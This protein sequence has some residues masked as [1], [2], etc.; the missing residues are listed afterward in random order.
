MILE[1]N[2]TLKNNNKWR[3]ANWDQHLYCSVNRIPA[4]TSAVTAGSSADYAHAVSSRCGKAAPP[5][6]AHCFCLTAKTRRPC[7]GPISDLR[8]R[9]HRLTAAAACSQCG[10]SATLTWDF[11]DRPDVELRPRQTGALRNSISRA[12]LTFRLQKGCATPHS[13]PRAQAHVHLQPHSDWHLCKT[14]LTAL[15][16]PS[17]PT[18]N[19]MSK[20]H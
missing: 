1:I 16:K 6:S 10:W 20:W 18:S 15:I 12:P 7:R 5:D 17:Y 13:D 3:N 14:L 2:I 9:R 19:G 11:S 8:Y 4:Q